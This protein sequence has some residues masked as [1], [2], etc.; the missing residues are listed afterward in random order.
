MTQLTKVQ[1][2]KQTVRF[3]SKDPVGRRSVGGGSNCRYNSDEG[4]HCAVGRCLLGKYQRS[5]TSLKGNISTFKDFVF[6]NVDLKAEQYRELEMNTT[7]HHD[8]V[9]QKKYR[10]HDMEFWGKLQALHDSPTYW[11]STGLT[12]FGKQYVNKL[13]SKYKKEDETAN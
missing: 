6:Y 9:L 10:G 5:G 8:A 2:I 13:I 7:S 11:T 12:T 1:I 3:Y 4:Q